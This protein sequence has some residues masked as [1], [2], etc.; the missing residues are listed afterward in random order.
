MTAPVL[1]VPFKTIHLE[2]VEAAKAA[3][4]EAFARIGNKDNY[5]C[6]FAWVNV[7]E[8]KLS[9]K[10]GKEFAAL[11]FKKSYDGGIDLW[12]PSGSY[13]Q[14]MDVKYAGAVAYAKVL[15]KYGIIASPRERMD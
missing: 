7:K 14:N 12:N 13:V 5:P 11:D 6:G 9:T 1:S 10:L 8:V 15:R 2:A 3:F 4:T